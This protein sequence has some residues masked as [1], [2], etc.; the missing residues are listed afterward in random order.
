MIREIISRAFLLIAVG[1]ALLYGF[2]LFKK[3]Q[4]KSAIAA[5]LNLICGDSSFF[6][7]FSRE[8]AN[9]TLIRAIGLLAEADSIGVNADK[10]IDAAFGIKTDWFT[11]EHKED[12]VPMR[13]KIIRASLRG[14]YENFIKLGYN[15]TPAEIRSIKDG[16]MPPIPSGPHAGRNPVIQS[17]IPSK[18]SPGM[19]KV[20]ANLELSPPDALDKPKTDIQIAAAKQL[21]RNLA[22]AGLIERSASERILTHLTPSDSTGQR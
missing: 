17:L 15:P 11:N 22:E 9:K 16:L 6:Q 18:A 20:I 4:R 10:A 7:Q 21:A 2:G 12:D 13:E 5:Q 19:E 14:N 1:V 8:E 3:H